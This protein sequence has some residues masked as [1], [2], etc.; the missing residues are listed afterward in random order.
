MLCYCKLVYL[1]AVILL[2]L[3]QSHILLPNFGLEWARKEWASSMYLKPPYFSTAWLVLHVSYHVMIRCWHNKL[4]IIVSSHR[5]ALVFVLTYKL[6]LL[7]GP[8]F[9]YKT[10]PCN[11]IHFTCYQLIS[12]CVRTGLRQFVFDKSVASCQQ[13]CYKL[14]WNPVFCCEQDCNIA[15]QCYN[16][17]VQ[18][19]RT[20]LQSLW[21][22]AV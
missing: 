20:K 3:L 7:G 6:G 9:W 18:V 10:M 13:I 22:V 5:K 17:D 1:V 8:L 21:Q 16:I 4:N 11:S 15:M 19:A 2:E 12:D 14:Q